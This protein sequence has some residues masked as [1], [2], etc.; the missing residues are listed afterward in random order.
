MSKER[1]LA[2][3]D[4]NYRGARIPVMEHFGAL[5]REAIIEL[6]GLDPVAHPDRLE[7]T[8]DK[9]AEALEVDLLW[10]GPLKKAG[11]AEGIVDW[12]N[13]SSIRDGSGTE[14]VQ[15]GI[16]SAV[17][18]E[19][20]RHYTFIPQPASLDEAL[21]FDPAPWFPDSVDQLTEKF[22]KQHDDMLARNGDLCYSLPNWYTTAFHF[23]LS[24]FGFELLCEAGLEEDRFARLMERFVAISERVTTAW[25]RVEGLRGFICHDDLTMTSGPLFRPEWYRRH[26]F[27]HYPRI[28]APLIDDAGVPILF[29]S[30]GDCTEFI[31]DIFDAGADGLNFE[32]I[33]DLEGLVERHPDRLLVGNLS[34]HLLAEG[35]VEKIRDEVTRMIEV[36]SG[37]RRYVANVGGQLT[38]DIPIEHLLAYLEIR[39]QRCRDAR[40]NQP[41]G[42]QAVVENTGKVR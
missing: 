10:G 17:H 35:P 23:P 42:E 21:D 18:A 22:Q 34:S 1:G 31:D 2:V 15:W 7:E 19:G 4:P 37:A 26:I 25:S 14:R 32:Y 6:T 20:G 33:V 38:H 11:A 8:W 28:F 12:T 41:E 16:F 36:G 5:S 40:R 39:K 9:L 24:I 29:T 30:D 3:L 27:P 13:R